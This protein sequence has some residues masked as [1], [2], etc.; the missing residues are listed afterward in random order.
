MNRKQTQALPR[1]HAGL[2]CA[3]LNISQSLAN[4]IKCL[5]SKRSSASTSGG[6]RHCR[7]NRRGSRPLRPNWSW[8]RH[9]SAV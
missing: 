3:G 7:G 5:A 9:D 1:P 2:A 4:E 6:K 8:K